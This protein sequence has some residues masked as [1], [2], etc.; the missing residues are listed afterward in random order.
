MELSDG[1]MSTG[2]KSHQIKIELYHRCDEC[3]GNNGNKEKFI[4]KG[5]FCNFYCISNLQLNITIH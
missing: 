3:R 2:R 1:Q 4:I 5:H